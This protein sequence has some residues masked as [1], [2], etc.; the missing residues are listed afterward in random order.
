MNKSYLAGAKKFKERIDQAVQLLP[1]DDAIQSINL[2]PTWLQGI[3]YI[4][5]Y[6]VSFNGGLYRCKQNHIS[7]EENKFDLNFWEELLQEVTE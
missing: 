7:N 1:L 6:K 2:F 3:E 5:G 4:Q